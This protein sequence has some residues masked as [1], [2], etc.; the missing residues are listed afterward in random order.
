MNDRKPVTGPL[1]VEATPLLVTLD[2]TPLISDNV[3]DLLNLLMDDEFF[4]TFLEIAVPDQ[5]GEHDGLADRLDFERLH[6]V[7]VDRLA[8]RVAL[9]GPQ[10]LR[11]AKRMQAFAEPMVTAQEQTTAALSNFAQQ[12]DRRAS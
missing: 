4:E 2:V 11:A 12:K 6:A 5:D 10:A 3:H 9:T 8:T 7:L 1:Y